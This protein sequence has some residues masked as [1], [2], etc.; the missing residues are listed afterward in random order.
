[1]KNSAQILNSIQHRPQFS[2]LS[3]YRCIKKIQSIFSPALQKMIKFA[4]IKNDILFF[5]LNHPG[6]KQE[7]DNNIQSI[8]SALKF[9]SPE[10]CSEVT[11]TDIKAFVTNKPIKKTTLFKTD[12]REEY[13]ER[14]TGNFKIDIK[15]EKLNSLIRSIQTIIKEKNDS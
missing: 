11:V 8:K 14:A 3:K 1:M 12:S 15:D 5:V 6:A 9:V 13:T 10:E 2:K 7:F 4:Y